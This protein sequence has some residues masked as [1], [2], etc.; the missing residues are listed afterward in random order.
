LNALEKFLLAMKRLTRFPVLLHMLCML[1][2]PEQQA[3]TWPEVELH[4]LL[5]QDEN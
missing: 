5:L 1:Y 4:Q 2:N 3:L